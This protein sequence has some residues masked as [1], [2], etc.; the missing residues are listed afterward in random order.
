MAAPGQS[1]EPPASQPQTQGS[2][3]PRLLLPGLGDR[4]SPRQSRAEQRGG[5]DCIPLPMG[6]V[7]QHRCNTRH[8]SLAR[9]CQDSAP[10]NKNRGALQPCDGRRAGREVLV[11]LPGQGPGSKGPAL[12]EACPEPVPQAWSL[13]QALHSHPGPCGHAIGWKSLACFSCHRPQAQDLF[14][15]FSCPWKAASKQPRPYHDVAL[16][17]L[18]P[19]GAIGLQQGVDHVLQL[20][21]LLSRNAIPGWEQG[22]C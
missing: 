2:F 3:P 13:R 20:V 17:H 10:R 9:L 15:L 22:G 5:A 21:L 6:L 12:A 16:Q 4:A 7:G 18:Q 1:T 14:A 19:W 11:L 8:G